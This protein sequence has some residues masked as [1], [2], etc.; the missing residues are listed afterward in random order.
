MQKFGSHTRSELPR[1]LVLRSPAASVRSKSDACGQQKGSWRNSVW[2]SV[3]ISL[4][5]DIKE[6]SKNEYH[7]RFST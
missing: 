6:R 7:F 1:V 2:H 5:V 3:Q 4:T